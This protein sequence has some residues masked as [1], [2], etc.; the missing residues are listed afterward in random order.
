MSNYYCLN[1]VVSTSLLISG[2]SSFFKMSF[3]PVRNDICRDY[4]SFEEF[5]LWRL[6]KDQEQRQILQNRGLIYI[7]RRLHSS[8]KHVKDLQ[9][10]V[11]KCPYL[12][13]FLARDCL[14]RKT[15]VNFNKLF[16][17]F[18]K[19]RTFFGSFSD[20]NLLRI[21]DSRLCGSTF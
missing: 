2:A 18:Q 3:F 13:K 11:I 10:N 9:N 6:G 1:T 17:S 16:P 19:G 20:H 21:F 15:Y 5:Q 12:N 7:K 4:V 14:F 8:T